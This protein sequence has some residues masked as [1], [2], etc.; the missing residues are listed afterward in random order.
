MNITKKKKLNSETVQTI[1]SFISQGVSE[2][3]AVALAGIAS[4]RWSKWLQTSAGK[5]AR[6]ACDKAAAEWE[7]A[8]IKSINCSSNASTKLAALQARIGAWNTKAKGNDTKEQ[9]PSAAMFAQLS[10]VPE[11]VKRNQ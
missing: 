10:A 11:R 3:G 7:L 6:L 2:K 8:T 1:C 5:S 4:T 9:P